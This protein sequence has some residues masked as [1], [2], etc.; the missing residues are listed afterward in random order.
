MNKKILILIS[1]LNI[2]AFAVD[3]CEKDFMS[4]L[5]YATKKVKVKN[6][7]NIKNIGSYTVFNG[8]KNLNKQIA[9][10]T[11]NYIGFNFLNEE[12]ANRWIDL[13][14]TYLQNEKIHYGL[15][16]DIS[17]SDVFL[18]TLK[19]IGLFVRFNKK[20]IKKFY[21]ELFKTY[22]FFS[23]IFQRPTIEKYMIMKNL[24]VATE[25]DLVIYLK[26]ILSKGEIYDDHTSDNYYFANRYYYAFFTKDN[27]KDIYPKLGDE[28]HSKRAVLSKLVRIC[29]N[30]NLVLEQ[31]AMLIN[32]TQLMDLFYE[33]IVYPDIQPYIEKY[34]IATG[35]I[36]VWSFWNY[37]YFKIREDKVMTSHYFQL[38]YNKASKIMK[39]ELFYTYIK[40]KTDA[41]SVFIS[42]GDNYTAYESAIELI[43]ELSMV[44]E[45]LTDEY[46]SLV[47]IQKEII[48]DSSAVILEK[49]AKSGDYKTYNKVLKERDQ[50]VLHILKR[51]Y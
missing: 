16:M 45:G 9:K 31:R 21:L 22:D 12:I 6:I 2:N 18:K 19:E 5:E 40:V 39:K 23:N 37:E 4:N 35:N 11:Y 27:L 25:K 8:T 10:T 17:E 36:L 41:L 34:F 14:R 30:R 38:Y 20:D 44:Q 24:D 32:K 50:S 26:H 46:F 29:E 1:I 7:K 47:N 49:I 51:K 15:D 43:A 48:N 13:A 42:K 3:F 33:S 28:V